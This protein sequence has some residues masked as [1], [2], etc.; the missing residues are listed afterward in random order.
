MSSIGTQQ[1]IYDDEEQSSG[2]GP[3]WGNV[4]SFG[5]SVVDSIFG[6]GGSGGNG[7]GGSETRT[8]S[9]GRTIIIEGSNES[10]SGPSSTM[11]M[12]VVGAI[13][14]VVAVVLVTQKR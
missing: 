11:T 4:L 6:G 8:G 5:S 13:V 10:Q 14:A 3:G 9:D 7:G 12:L 2:N 1:Y